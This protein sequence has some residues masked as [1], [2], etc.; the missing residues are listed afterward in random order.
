M[1]MTID[2][3]PPRLRKY[4]GMRPWLEDPFQR[5]H[6]MA[7]NLITEILAHEDTPFGRIARNGLLLNEETADFI[8]KGDFGFIPKPY[9][10]GS[11]PLLEAYIDSVTTPGMSDG[12][13]VI[14]LCQSMDSLKKRFPPV[15]CFL[16]GE[17]DEQTLLKGGG[18]CSCRG[19]LLSALCQVLGIQARPA[20]MWAWVDPKE[21]DKLLGGHTVAEA[22][23]DG[24][25]GFFD[26]QHH[27]Y[28]RTHDGSFPGILQIREKPELFL[29]MPAEEVAR[30]KPHGYPGFAEGRAVFEYYWYKNFNPLC[31]ISISRHDVNEPY[32]GVWNWA[33][34][35][36]RQRQNHDYDESKAILLGMA[37]RGELTERVYRMNVDEFRQHAG[38]K[39]WQVPSYSERQKAGE[40]M[41]PA[42]G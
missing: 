5:V 10:K 6:H 16:Y 32:L 17:S 25:W 36:F 31:P 29:D 35:D 4:A 24:Q 12:E 19:R 21:P 27:C 14:A 22:Y 40:F 8:Y 42:A 2:L 26:P 38:I 39:D 15:P 20:M 28:C 23:I 3:V 13:K 37:A 41:K 30:M 1:K 7:F 11:R 34:P 18:H 9:V 33:T